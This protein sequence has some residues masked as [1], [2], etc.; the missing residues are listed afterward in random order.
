MEMGIRCKFWRCDHFEC[1]PMAEM[2]LDDLAPGVFVCLVS[3]FTPK[4]T[5]SCHEWRYCPSHPCRWTLLGCGTRNMP[6]VCTYIPFQKVVCKVESVA[7]VFSWRCDMPGG[8]NGY[9]LAVTNSNIP[10]TKGADRFSTEFI[11][12]VYCGRWHKEALNPTSSRRTT[13][14]SIRSFYL[15]TRSRLYRRQHLSTWSSKTRTIGT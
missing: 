13:Y 8:C 10:T 4:G 2:Y 6:L 3:R 14:S 5:P 1:M 15:V 7:S 12:V 11:F 9:L